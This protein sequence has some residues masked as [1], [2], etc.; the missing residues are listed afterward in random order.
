MPSKRVIHQ[1]LNVIKPLPRE[2]TMIYS[3]TVT[4]ELGAVAEC[5]NTKYAYILLLHLWFSALQH[6]LNSANFSAMS[7]LALY[8]HYRI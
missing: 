4:A 7:H 8:E 1:F 2:L 3:R 5:I 6:F